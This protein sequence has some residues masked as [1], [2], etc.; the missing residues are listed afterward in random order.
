MNTDYRDEKTNLLYCS[1]ECGVE[2]GADPMNLWQVSDDDADFPYSQ[3][4]DGALC[5]CGNEYSSFAFG[6][7]SDD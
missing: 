3:E 7:D 6:G 4:R 2:D 1:E 5:L